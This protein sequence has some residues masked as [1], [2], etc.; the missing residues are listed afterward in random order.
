MMFEK[1][2]VLYVP[3]NQLADA[4]AYEEATNGINHMMMLDFIEAGKIVG[5]DA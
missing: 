3:K 1:D 5:V 2:G 4:L